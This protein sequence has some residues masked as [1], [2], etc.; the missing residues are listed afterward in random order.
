VAGLGLGFLLST[1]AFLFRPPTTLPRA[2]HARVWCKPPAQEEKVRKQGNLGWFIPFS[3]CRAASWDA[4]AEHD[5][6]WRD[7]QLAEC[8]F[9]FR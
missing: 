9:H 4:R 1:Q 8:A 2:P 3:E 7:V 5:R 6:F